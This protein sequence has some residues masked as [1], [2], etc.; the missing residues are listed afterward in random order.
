MLTNKSSE[1]T[2]ITSI[3]VLDDG[4]PAL[5]QQVQIMNGEHPEEFAPIALGPGESRKVVLGYY[6]T[7]APDCVFPG[8]QTYANTRQDWQLLHNLFLEHGRTFPYCD[9][10][11]DP[12]TQTKVVHS[13][14]AFT[15]RTAYGDL[16]LRRPVETVQFDANGG[17][18]IWYEHPTPK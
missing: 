10:L 12:P 11:P 1:A 13:A 6:E 8:L 3:F 5:A 9:K 17:Y 2:S 14:L 18:S 16:L 7:I 4:E 15:I